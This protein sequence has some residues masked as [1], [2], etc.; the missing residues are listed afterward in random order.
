MM[1]TGID[2]TPISGTEYKL[3]S[4]AFKVMAEAAQ[5]SL[6]AQAYFM[7]FDTL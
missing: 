6:A 3:L 7:A 2:A 4:A 1:N 5:C